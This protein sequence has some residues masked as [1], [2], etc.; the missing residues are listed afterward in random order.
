MPSD[1]RYRE[2]KKLLE[3]HGWMHDRTSGSHHIF[4]G[5]GLPMVSI[6]VHHGKVKHVYLREIQKQIEAR[7][8]ESEKGNRPAL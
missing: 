5:P 1:V 8:K 2:I 4:S 6:P 3:S 7:R